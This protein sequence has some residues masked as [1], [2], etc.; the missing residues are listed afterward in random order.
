MK[1]L[2]VALAAVIVSCFVVAGTPS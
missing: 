2:W 1:R